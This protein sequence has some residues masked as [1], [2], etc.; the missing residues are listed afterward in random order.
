MLRRTPALT[1]TIA[2]LT[3]LALRHARPAQAQDQAFTRDIAARGRVFLEIGPGVSAIKRDAAGRYYV[4][5][6]PETAVLIYGADGN[7]AGQI[8]NANSKSA[9]IVYASDIDLDAD[10]RLFVADRGANAVKIFGADGSLDAT[11]FVAAPLSIAALSG[12]EFA[13]T[14]L[15]AEKLVSVYNAQGTLERTFG[16]LPAPAE[17][18]ERGALFT[19]GRLYGDGAGQI[20]FVFTELPD[21]TIRKYD[22]FGYAAYEI[23]LPASEFKPP[24]EAK[25]W[26]T[27]TIGKD[28]SAPPKPVIQALAADPETHEVWAAI[29]DEL[30]HFDQDG[31]RRSAYHMT[32]KAGTPI[33]ASAILVEHDR[34]LVGD[35]PNG[36]F[37]FAYPEMRHAASLSH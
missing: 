27:L 24:R 21:P 12:G 30:L 20:H 4:L 18:G 35:D 3:A 37:D 32:T 13:V 5:A 29:G 23:S 33:E 14:S 31:S 28:Q 22:R 7:R 10:G 6:A 15:R 19:S 36:I 8:P 17:G 26:T 34:I 25:Q 16:D 2:A 1:L 11:V 9:R